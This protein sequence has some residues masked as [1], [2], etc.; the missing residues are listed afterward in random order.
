MHNNDV[1]YVTDECMSVL[2][3]NHL[4]LF[5]TLVKRRCRGFILR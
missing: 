5:V 1:A 3:K 2:T 4:M